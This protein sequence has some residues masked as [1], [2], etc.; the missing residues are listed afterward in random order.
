MKSKKQNIE[1][2][3]DNLNKIIDKEKNIA[4]KE[5]IDDIIKDLD[6]R[7]KSEKK[8]LQ[9][10]NYTSI[11]LLVMGALLAVS[12][13]LAEQTS[14][15]LYKD[16]N[17][18]RNVIERLKRTDSIFVEIMSP[19]VDS[20]TGTSGYYYAT[21][22]GKVVTYPMLK[23]KHD[24]LQKIVSDLEHKRHIDSLKLYLAKK[25]YNIIFNE[26]KN[27]ISIRAPHI[28]SAML[29]L[30]IYRDRISYDEHKQLW[31]IKH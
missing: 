8:N 24:S 15:L 18:K 10:S 13:F 4:Q 30:P 25:R 21:I 17:E 16:I 7:F 12:L 26:T 19:E 27:S 23:Q 22:N 6:D 9:T 14:D 28:D 3:L 5:L 29:L 2:I 31:N 1:D 11:G 20:T